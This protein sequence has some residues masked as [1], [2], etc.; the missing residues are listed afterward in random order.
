MMIRPWRSAKWAGTSF[1]P[2]EPNKYGPPMSSASAS[3]PERALGDAVELRG[4]ERAGRHRSPVLIARP[5]DRPAAGSASSR[6]A[7]K[8]RPIWP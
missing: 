3:A 7:I 5:P 1:Q 4:G 8:K 6:L 2:S